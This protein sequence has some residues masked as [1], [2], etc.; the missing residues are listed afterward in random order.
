MN[1]RQRRATT[2]T[3]AAPPPVVS[4]NLLEIFNGAVR[5]HRHGRL[6]EAERRYRQLL[7]IDPRHADALHLLGVIAHQVGRNEVAVAMIGSAIGID[8]T[9]APYHSNLGLALQ[10]LGRL[11]EALTA[12]D[13]AIRLLPD[14]ADG[15]SNR[16]LALL[17]ARRPDEAFAAFATAIRHKPDFVEAHFNRGVA[18]IDLHR[19]DSAI[20]ALRTTIVLKPDLTGAY[21]RLGNALSKSGLA[22]R[23][24]PVFTAAV[25]LT[26]DD[27]ES[28]ANMGVALEASGGWVEA[29][30][31]YNA[32]LRVRPDFAEV[33]FNLGN[34]L[35]GAGH[36]DDAVAAFHAAIRL[37]PDYA[38][39]HSNLGI[40][41]KGLGRLA[42][43]AAAIHA[44]IAFRPDFA[45]A[46]CNLGIA[47]VEL[48]RFGQAM[49]AYDTAVRLDPDCA[50]AHYNKSHAH[51]LLG[52]L[53]TGWRD[54][55]WRWRGGI[56]GLVPRVFAQP[57]WG[58]EVLGG[59]TVLL[60]AEQGMGDTIQFCRYAALVAERGGRVVLEAPRSMA[61]LLTGLTGVDR[62]IAGGDPLPAFDLHCPLMSLPGLFGTTVERVPGP[63]PYLR[64][65]AAAVARWRAR[66]GATGFKIG[67]AWQGNPAAA[68]E[69]GRSA[70][71]ACFAPLAAVPGVRLI[72]LQKIHGLDQL[73]H[74]P[75]GMVVE[76]L[77]AD[78]DDGPDAFVDTAAV[79]M[80]LDLVITVD[81]A[82]GH[83]AG[84]LDRPVWLALQA[85]PHWVW[86]LERDDSPWY[87]SARLF[88][89]AERGQWDEVFTRMAAALAERLGAPRPPL[90]PASPG[91]GAMLN[92]AFRRHQAGRLIDAET[93]YRQI[94][95]FDPGHADALHLLGVIAHQRGR[96]D[97][98]IDLIRTAIGIH[99]EA[100][101]YYTNLAS[102]LH[103]LGRF[104]EAE[105]ICHAAIVVE[106][107]EA[108][109]YFNLGNSLK[110]LAKL[111]G[112]LVAYDIAIRLRPDFAEA[113]YNESF[114]HFLSGDFAR[115]WE[116]F[117]WRWRGGSTI[118]RPRP[119]AEP[120]WH[121]EDIAGR[122]ILLHAEQGMG[123]TIQFC[124]YA[125]LVAQRGGR[126][127]LEAPRS[128]LRLLSGLKG[129]ER[130]IAAGDP[131]PAFDLH[132]PLMSVPGLLA[133]RVETIPAAQPYLRAGED[134]VARW[135]DRLGPSGFK[136]GIVWQGNPTAA[137]E[138]GRSAPLACFAPL[139]RLP[140]VRLISLQKTH[141][142]DQLDHLP[143][144]MSVETLGADFDA[145]PDAFVDTAAVMM[146]LD[147]V[148]TVDTAAGHLAGALG[149][150]AWL[151]LQAV[152][153]WVWML[154]RE[155][156]PWYPSVRLFRQSERGNWDEVFDRMAAVLS[157]RLAP[158]GGPPG[159]AASRWRAT[160]DD[161]FRHHQAGRLED[162]ERRYRQILA[163][164]PG[165]ADAL[166][167]LG[168]IAHQRGRNDH[169]VALI[170]KAIGI[171]ATAAVFHF[172]LATALHGLGRLADAATSGRTAIR[173]QPDDAEAHTNLGNFLRDLGMLDGAFAAQRRA[174]CLKPDLA[175]AYS[176]LG[177]ALKSLR[178][179]DG[180][181]AAYQT[182]IHLR[183]DYGEAH[184][185]ES[186]V[187][188]LRG[189]LARGWP[190]YEWRWRGGS[191]TLTPV[192][193]LQPPWDGGDLAGRTIL[194]HAEQGMG[195]TI[196]FCRYAALVAARGGRVVLVA[197]R[198]L[199]RLLAGLRGV[200]H[201]VSAGDPLPAFDAHCPL[202]SLPGLFGTTVDTIPAPVPYLQADDVAIARW[203][204]RLGPSGF[205]VGIAWQ[206][207]PAARERSAPLACFA[208]LAAVQ[209]V[210]LISLQKTH[211]LD[212]LDHCPS[213]MVVETLGADFD[214][215][216]D[217]FVDTAAVMM[218]LDLVITVDTAIGHLAGALGRPVWL[219][220]P[221]VPHWVWM[222]ERDDSPWY[223][224]AR[225]FRQQERGQW[226][227]LFARMATVLA[228]RSGAPRQASSAL[229]GMVET[230]ARHHRAGRLADA[231]QVCHRILA[232]HPGHADTLHRLGVIAHQ[233]G[234][235]DR[236]IGLI[237][238]AIGFDAMAA[239]YHANLG[240]ALHGIGRLDAA[241]AASRAAIVIEADQVD[242]HANLGN[243]LRDLARPDESLAAYR[244]TLR[245]RPDFAKAHANLANALMEWQRFDEAVIAYRTAI[246]IAPDDADTYYN[247]GHAMCDQAWLDEA[248]AAFRKA[249][250]LRPDHAEAHYNESFVHFLRG[251]LARAWPQYEWRWRG[252]YPGLTSRAFPQPQWTGEEIGGRTVLVHAEQGMG[253]TILFCRYAALVAARGGR[254]VMETPR[255][256]VRL[257]SGLRGVERLIATGDPLPDFD[258]HCPLLSLP[259]VFGTTAETVPILVPY[260]R[261][262]DDAVARWRER[263]GSAGFKIGIVWQGN[264]AAAVDRG[265]SAPL[266]SFAPLARVPGAR[267]ISLQKI[268]GLEQLDQ[269]PPGMAVETLGPDFDAG[270]DAFI[271]AA[272]VMMSLD[273]VVT[274]DTAIGHL[275]GALGRPTWIALQA[276]PY[277]VWMLDRDDSPWYP[278]VRLFRQV[279]RGDWDDVACRMAA[280][281]TERS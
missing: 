198:P 34:A 257:L 206:G 169:A 117:E 268:H 60:H 229:Q 261:A 48:G 7:A 159:G 241:I 85:V 80:S 38:D 279:E 226:D 185:N 1:R 10:E 20:A 209:G 65:E 39:A 69:R 92:E 168:L 16:G 151:A 164:D 100:E 26:P 255:P 59:R 32:A 112:A 186:F 120:N 4:T 237:R 119:F 89:Q 277:W 234:R 201:L 30:A 223:P 273:L 220:L 82:I 187:H 197:P 163:S 262:D 50:G 81:T 22:D 88:R 219:A 179:L 247:Q 14:Y 54:Y 12:F 252:G 24:I 108:E 221:V 64:A 204:D 25:R 156:S 118:L 79:M 57:R 171:D 174:V 231:E 101:P 160:I 45:E 280:A 115:G 184:C 202:I 98:A 6:A 94:L 233:Q 228:E 263:L 37:K 61:R 52:D 235:N 107:S 181:L 13:A 137:I 243:F 154:G 157:A 44:A 236:A 210:R 9:A 153:H 183:P 51:L 253:D 134:A 71:L 77:G 103:D 73:D 266:E 225:L 2:K 182:A 167:L 72:S 113:H 78:F 276:V 227:E 138:R 175:E 47:L 214:D 66:L 31:S 90:P 106:P 149:R 272:A 127:V 246:A 55:E 28:H 250:R 205:K 208:P 5:L 203:R 161:A 172:N 264:P 271:D 238:A 199:L 207:G 147:L 76:T 269:R 193:F 267:L 230:A 96:N 146:S 152:P 99:A 116:K 212:Q 56:R 195:D 19:L 178:N 123:D 86:M 141:G 188:F 122:T 15:H 265:R 278:S 95:A 136:I 213:G 218:S 256:L 150:P 259:G 211:G 224:S 49:T 133:V 109:A 83:L 254:V 145:G 35:V 23:A 124:R 102:A 93:L 244:R 74:L 180:A 216:A 248:F 166:H 144:G 68:A 40:A 242:A 33:R 217:A 200:D 190:K 70:P 36:I 104:A 173:L 53:A 128:L 222:L 189:D 105:T 191:K 132:C 140:G 114:V 43:A 249:I 215:G 131:L 245:L 18:L 162:A 29:I 121:G 135:K 3:A 165:H 110:E 139:A 21:T 11:D 251:D 27:A 62:L 275:A 143:P 177:K 17:A 155:D 196:Q 130:L 8:G 260:L 42:D 129:P 158:A 270:A 176:G 87:P 274:V 75:A 111:D 91:L 142:L 281:L 148:V 170:G 126:V 63:V 258:L 58:G 41:L 240:I 232:S 239:P 46:Y 125:A 192:N 84:A 67:I 194:L 97:R